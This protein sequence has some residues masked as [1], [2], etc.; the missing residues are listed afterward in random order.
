MAQVAAPSAER[1]EPR[2]RVGLEVCAD[3][4]IDAVGVEQA[5]DAKS[6]GA[7]ADLT[8][9]RKVQCHVPVS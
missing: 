9:A 6:S 7:E 8:D 5:R 2:H 1:L 4:S 3:L